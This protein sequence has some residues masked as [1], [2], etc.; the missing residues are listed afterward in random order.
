MADS[1]SYYFMSSPASV[2]KYNTEFEHNNKKMLKD[3]FKLNEE[4]P[5]IHKKYLATLDL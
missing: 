3:F 1:N 5:E 2:D 4:Y